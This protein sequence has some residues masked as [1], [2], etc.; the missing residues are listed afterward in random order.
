MKTY[1]NI[2]DVK[3]FIEQA[4]KDNNHHKVHLNTLQG[5]TFYDKL[6]FLSKTI[7]SNSTKD[8]KIIVVSHTIHNA[9]SGYIEPYHSKPKGNNSICTLLELQPF[10][11]IHNHIDYYFALTGSNKNWI[12]IVYEDSCMYRE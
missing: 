2:S 4:K 12:L 5:K 11:K 3:D 7:I 6:E 8:A 10:G 9:I 1:S